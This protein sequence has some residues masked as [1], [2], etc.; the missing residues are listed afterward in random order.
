MGRF[1]RECF[2]GTITESGVND[3]EWRC[4][5]TEE[6]EQRATFT[7]WWRA[8]KCQRITVLPWWSETLNFC[9]NV[10]GKKNY[11]CSAKIT[12]RIIFNHQQ[13]DPYVSRQQKCRAC[14]I[15][16]LHAMQLCI[17]LKMIPMQSEGASLASWPSVALQ[18]PRLQLRR[19]I[20][21]DW[22]SVIL[23]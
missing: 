15:R 17:A 6:K 4:R 20:I 19:T 9:Q 14:S 1:L 5:I 2:S 11:C 8:T 21:Y 23:T 13:H 7:G 3:W 18:I 16:W 22:K 10:F 12:S